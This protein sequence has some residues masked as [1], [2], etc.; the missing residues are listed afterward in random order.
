MPRSELLQ[1]SLLCA[2]QS[3]A[4][5]RKVRRRTAGWRRS[6]L[7]T[8]YEAKVALCTVDGSAPASAAPTPLHVV[9]VTLDNHLSGPAERAAATLRGTRDPEHHACGFHAAA[10]FAEATSPPAS[11][12]CTQRHRARATSSSQRCC[13]STTISSA[14]LPALD[15]SARPLFDAMVGLMSGT[16]AS[17]SSPGWATIAWTS[18]PRARSHL[19]KKLRGSVQARQQ[20]LPALGPDENAASRLPKMLQASSPAPRRTCA[21][22][23]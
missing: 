6:T 22:I 15:R 12:A 20:G 11:I 17:S 2:R 16:R 23:S 10:D 5:H 14:V 4:K 9:I 3:A 21:P 18:P 19:L 13:F 7:D 1:N 8:L